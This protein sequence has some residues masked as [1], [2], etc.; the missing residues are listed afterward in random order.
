MGIWK[1]VLAWILLFIPLNAYGA[2]FYSE[3]T[4]RT[5]VR[6]I[7]NEASASFWTDDQ[8]DA[9]MEQATIDISARSLCYQ[10]SD[11]FLL[12]TSQYEYTDFV[13]AGAAAVVDVTKVWGCFYVS[14]DN[15]YIGL[16]RILV[17]QIADLP[18]MAAGPPKYYYQMADKIGILPLPTSAENGQS[19][20]IYYSKQ[21]NAIADLPNTYQ[22]LVIIYAAS[23]CYKKEHRYP[24]S[25]QLYN[26][27][28]EQLN[29]LKQELYLAPPEIKTK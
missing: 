5:Q 12:V 14:P 15:E 23:L 11:T 22:S 20:R 1:I 13:T 18:Y 28:M 24:E 9:F 27:Y 8:I 4:A 7:L 17:D 29:A 6:T 19:V 21:T 10:S 26:Q 16:K 3:S 2:D 25:T